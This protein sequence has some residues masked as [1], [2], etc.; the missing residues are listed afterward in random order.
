MRLP[1]TRLLSACLFSA[2]AFSAVPA[3]AA[4]IHMIPQGDL[5]ILDPIQNPSYITRNHGYMIYDTLFS[6]NAKGEVKPQMVDTWKVSAD[7]KTWTFTLR[8]GLKWSDGT[9]V[10]AADCV[11]S[12]K[13]WGAKDVSGRLLFAAV[14]EIK[15]IDAASFA[16]V[17]KAPFGPVLEMLGKPSSNV[18]FMMPERVAA[19][20]PNEQI[21]DTTGSGPFVFKRDEWV[22]GSKVVYVKNPHYLPRQEPADGL[23]GG[24]VV[25]VDRVEWNYI[26]DQNTALTAFRN[27]EMDVYELPPA[28]FITPLAGDASVKLATDNL[29]NQGWLRPNH[30]AAP[31]D[32]PK[33]RQAL[34]Y[35]VNQDEYLAAAGFPQDYRH[36]TC[37]AYFMCGSV[38]ETAA[39]ATPY[40]A[41][42]NLAKAKQLLQE[43]GYKGEKIVVLAPSE[44]PV[45]AAAAMVT[46]QNLK[47]IGVN[48]EAQAM[49]WS[50]LLA[51]RSKKEGWHIF[52]TFSVGADVFSPAVNAYA[53]ANCDKAPSGWP[54]DAR[55]EELRAAWVAEGDATKRK[56]ITDEL[57]TRMYEV[58]PYVNFGQFFQPMAY[59]SNLS[60]VLNVGVPVMWNIEKK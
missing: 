24:K 51:R 28:D 49:D 22:P 33:A 48:V 58:V 30:L 29:G 42:Q 9:P 19:T 25:K 38:N 21:K 15:A 11:A 57:Q 13:R 40:A 3:L 56:A 60:G 46:I 35:L 41:G 59:R 47:K 37:T 45:Q 5:K 32:N 8:S 10:T 20:D 55:L 27:G 36:K 39:G 6:Q 1:A 2:A 17:L 7:Q 23:A 16:I 43:A 4:T 14:G 26:P 31:F 34:Y 53:Q 18:P 44:P 12:L 52:H 50:T 54:C